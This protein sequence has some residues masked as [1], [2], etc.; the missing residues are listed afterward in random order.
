[1]LG[2]HLAQGTSPAASLKRERLVNRNAILRSTGFL[3][4]AGGAAF[5]G[6]PAPPRPFPGCKPGAYSS[7][8]LTLTMDAIIMPSHSLAHR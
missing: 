7:R 8:V 1:M 5:L 2:L 6:A 3:E 4:E